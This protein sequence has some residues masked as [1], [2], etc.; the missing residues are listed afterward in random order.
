MRKG[1]ARRR[2]VKIDWIM[3]YGKLCERLEFAERLKV[4]SSKVLVM[5]AKMDA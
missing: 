5:Y 4:H 2:T 1:A 3:V